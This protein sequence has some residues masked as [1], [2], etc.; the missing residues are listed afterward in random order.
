MKLVSLKEIRTGQVVGKTM[1]FELCM[2]NNEI[3]EHVFKH[4]D[5]CFNP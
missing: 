1:C 3:S 5:M 4:K 2:K